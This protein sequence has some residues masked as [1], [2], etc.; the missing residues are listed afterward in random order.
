LPDEADV[1]NEVVTAGVKVVAFDWVMEEGTHLRRCRENAKFTAAAWR[2]VCQNA[3]KALE[4]ECGWVTFRWLLKNDNNWWKILNGEHTATYKP[5]AKTPKQQGED[6]LEKEREAI[7]ARREAAK[8]ARD[9]RQGAVGDGTGGAV[10]G[11]P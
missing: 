9:E 3:Q 4:N 6:F 2:V 5:K 11:V 8:R 1:W 10:A 7:Y